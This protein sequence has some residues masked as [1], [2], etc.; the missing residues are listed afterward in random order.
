MDTAKMQ[1]SFDDM[2]RIR[3]LEA[4]M[5]KQTENLAGESTG[6]VEKIETF[7][8]KV[9]SLLTVLSAQSKKIETAK[10]LAIGQKNRNKNALEDRRR[11]Q[12]ELQTQILLKKQ[13]LERIRQYNESLTKTFMEQKQI[14]EKFKTSG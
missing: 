6:F 13:Q 10:L 2:N 14:I 5:F 3:I 8:K 11:L 9:A 12:A 4:D 7:N 1:I